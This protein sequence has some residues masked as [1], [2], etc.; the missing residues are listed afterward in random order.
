MPAV[1]AAPAVEYTKPTYDLEP[2]THA[3]LMA[4]PASELYRIDIA[5]VNLLCASGMPTTEGLDV[6]RSLA[7]LDAWAYKVAFETDRHLYRVHDPRYA[8]RY[9]GSEAH[10]RAEMLAQVLQENLGVRYN[11]KAVGN[12]SFADASMGFIHGMIPSPDQTMTDCPAAPA[13]RC[14]CC[15]SPWAGVWATRSNSP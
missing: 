13:R 9:G 2:Q 14:R 3:E 4:V 15:M 1:S 11:M 7:T 8:D 12:F 10:F 6:E 5:R